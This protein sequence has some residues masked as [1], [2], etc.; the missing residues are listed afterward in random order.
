MVSARPCR[1][2]SAWTA[3]KDACAPP[4]R[5]V[6]LILCNDAKQTVLFVGDSSCEK[7]SSTTLR[8]EHIPQAIK[9]EGSAIGAHERLNES[10]RHWIV[11]V[12]E[13]V[14]EIADPKFAIHESK[15]PWGIE[16]PICD[17]APE[18]IVTNISPLKFR[19]PNGA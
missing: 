19:I 13:P 6:L 7:H 16:V 17:E 10:A 2:N 5:A 11:N 1:D 9:L 12:N 18:E 15:A 8:R 3:D 14:A 4:I